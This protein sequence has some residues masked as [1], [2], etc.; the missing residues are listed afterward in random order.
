MLYFYHF[1]TVKI[2]WMPAGSLTPSTS[3]KQS[4]QQ[5]VSCMMVFGGITKKKGLF[6]NSCHGG[7]ITRLF[8]APFPSKMFFSHSKRASVGQEVKTGV[9]SPSL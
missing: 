7:W 2:R 8:C 9:I 3:V 4:W 1:T 5:H 6:M